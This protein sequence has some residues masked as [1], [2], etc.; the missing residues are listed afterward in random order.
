MAEEDVHGCPQNACILGPGAWDCHGDYSLA[1]TSR[2]RRSC[3]SRL[4]SLHGW[5]A[6][7]A[8]GNGTLCLVCG[9]IH[10]HWKRNTSAHRCAPHPGQPESLSMD[11]QSYVCGSPFG[12]DRG[13]ILFRS[14]LL[15]GYALLL[16]SSSRSPRY[17][18]NSVRAMKRMCI[19]F[20]AGFL[21]SHGDDA[22]SRPCLHT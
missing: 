5:P 14:L 19:P 22:T 2:S 15:A 4:L 1:S 17:A 18:A 7:S 11:A 9:S 21:A 13:A 12:S 10:L 6:Y 3:P 8:V 16:W 20:H